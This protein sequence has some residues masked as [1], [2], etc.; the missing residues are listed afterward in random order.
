MEITVHYLDDHYAEVHIED[1]RFTE[2][3]SG[4]LDKDERIALA[5]KFIVAADELM[6]D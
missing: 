1:C 5:Q 6:R 4:V 3:T 2:I